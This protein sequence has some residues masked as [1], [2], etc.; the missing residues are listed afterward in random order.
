MTDV[1]R[2]F[3]LRSGSGSSTSSWLTHPFTLEV[4]QLCTLL[5]HADGQSRSVILRLLLCRVSAG[6]VEEQGVWVQV[7]LARGEEPFP[8]P[9]RLKTPLL[10][11]GL[12]G[13]FYLRRRL[14]KVR[15]QGCHILVLQIS[16][17]IIRPADLLHL[18]C[19][20][21]IEGLWNAGWNLASA[22]WQHN[23]IA[24]R[25]VLIGFLF[26]C[27]FFFSLPGREHEWVILMQWVIQ[28]WESVGMCVNIRRHTLDCFMRVCVSDSRGI[29]ASNSTNVE[30]AKQILSVFFWHLSPGSSEIM[31]WVKLR[32]S[33]RHL[34]IWNLHCTKK[35]NN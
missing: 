22:S 7:L 26:V 8:K 4:K 13:C 14:N 17:T 29:V 3:V 25:G 11:F 31:L 2:V 32:W 28:R 24:V 35:K 20:A 12:F 15:E 16:D 18:L 6:P 21:F 34:S 1:W 19:S 27:Y 30:I 23:S 33:T 9:G 10:L 5:F